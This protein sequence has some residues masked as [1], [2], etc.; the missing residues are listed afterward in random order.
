LVYD[1]QYRT[2]SNRDFV[3]GPALGALQTIPVPPSQPITSYV[4][5]TAVQKQVDAGSPRF[6][7]RLQFEKPQ[8]YNNQADYMALGEGRTRLIIEYQD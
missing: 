5:A 1:C 8:F 6:Q 4:L 7:L 3:I 2:L